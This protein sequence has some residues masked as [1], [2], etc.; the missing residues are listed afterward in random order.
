MNRPMRHRQKGFTLIELLVVI[1]IIGILT[2]L[3]VANFITAKAR[4]R[5]AQRKSDLAQMRSA[6]ELYRTDTASYPTN[7]LLGSCGPS[8]S[9]Q[10]GGTTYLQQ[11]PCDPLTGN[12]Y[13]Y[14]NTGAGYTITAC[15][16]NKNDSQGFTDNSC[17]A[18][19][20]GYKVTN[21]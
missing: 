20:W 19:K 4:A 15:L 1:A 16:E 7:A 14:N 10:S 12:K 6:L 11:I 3:L 2:S 13:N 18:P 8:Q 21:P 17:P 9:L 5:D